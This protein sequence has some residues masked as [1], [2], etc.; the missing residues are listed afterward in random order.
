M[1]K[2]LSIYSDTELREEL[3]KRNY[4][5][6]KSRGKA[7]SEFLESLRSNKQFIELLKLNSCATSPVD[8]SFNN[9]TVTISLKY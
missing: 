3:E 8:I 6:K 9:N 7:N 4:E 5:F 2:S 1:S